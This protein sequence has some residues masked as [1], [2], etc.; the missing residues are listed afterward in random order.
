[1]QDKVTIGIP[2]FN[3]E[4]Y[5]EKT[6]YSALSQTY[7]N[8]EIIISDNSSQDGSL[9]IIKN[10]SATHK[11]IRYYTQPINI[12]ALDN[13]A[14]ILDKCTSNYFMFLGGHDF[15]SDNYVESCLL[16]LLKAPNTILASAR[17][18]NQITPHGVYNENF[19]TLN[20]LDIPAR[21]AILQWLWQCHSCSQFYGLFRTDVLKKVGLPKI[22]APDIAVIA[23]TLLHGSAVHCPQAKYFAT[24]KRSQE[25]IK[26][27]I[28][29]YD[30]IN[31][32]MR[33][34]YIKHINKDISTAYL[35]HQQCQNFIIS[36][37]KKS[38]M[39]L[40]EKI[41]LKSEIIKIFKY[42]FS[43]RINN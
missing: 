24:C 19:E 7:K 36:S 11:N 22:Y 21:L 25:S 39:K 16:R 29:R 8:I 30:F 12:S 2:V 15:I 37:V 14:F 23:A 32:K 18:F 42:R 13:F 5:L 1:M 10:L 38:S 17:I 33:D 6:I 43:Y 4:S 20:T 31:N 26:E 3:E 28:T 40:F 41:I 35:L 27:T 34:S 9:Q